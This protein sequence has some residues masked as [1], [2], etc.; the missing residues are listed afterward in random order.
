DR[1]GALEAVDQDER[2]GGDEVERERG[3]AERLLSS[4]APLAARED[5]QDERA[6]AEER[7]GGPRP[8]LVARRGVPADRDRDDGKHEPA[9]ADPGD[10]ALELAL[11]EEVEPHARLRSA[12]SACSRS[13]GSSLSANGLACSGSPAP[14]PS[15]ISA[16]RRR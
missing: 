13:S 12:H 6:D 16:F 15:A 11:A 7:R 2:R 4:R 9:D 8:R 14:L 5:E 3:Q 1:A 10:P